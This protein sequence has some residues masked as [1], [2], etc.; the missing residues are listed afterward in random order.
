MN[1]STV[2]CAL[3]LVFAATAVAQEPLKSLL[4]AR[5][6]H[7]T[8]LVRIAAN[9]DPLEEPPRQLF[10]IVKYKS[11]VGAISAYLGADPEGDGKHPAIIWIT[12]GIPPGG[13]GSS[14][15]RREPSENDQSA[16]CYRQAGMVMM[17]PTLRGSFGNPGNQES[18][19]GEV[20]D[21]LAAA[22]Y[23]A[24]VPYVDPERI[25]LG[26]HSTGGTLALLVA[27]ATDR[28]KAIFSF[29]P[30]ESPSL[31]SP[32]NLTYDPEERT[33]NR[34][35][36]PIHFLGAIQ[37]PTFVIEGTGG[38]IEPF[39]KL[40]LACKNPKVVFLPVGDADHFK[41]LGPSNNVIAEKI[42]KLGSKAALSL[43][44][45]ELEKACA[46]AE[47]SRPESPSPAP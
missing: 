37:S 47:A 46:T 19:Y 39:R 21:I 14:A 2:F 40:Q 24:K 12:G 13:I 32:G 3:S 42:A 18:F 22:D 20:D 8:K 11:P 43:T 23:L 45:F 35:R 33:E 28:F 25:Y 30:V 4:D 34:L 1:R 27:A 38:Y 7:K 44:A 6:S 10:K 31:Y 15:W 17:Y 29:G 16:K 36:S 26:G 5:A 41:V 9:S